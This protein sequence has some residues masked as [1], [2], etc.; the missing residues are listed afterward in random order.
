MFTTLAETYMTATRM[1]AIFSH[2]PPVSERVHLLQLR[3]AE[4]K[5]RHAEIA[6]QA[7]RVRRRTMARATLRGTGRLLERTG[8]VLARAGHALA[9]EPARRQCC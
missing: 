8:A 9:A 5:A 1:D 7:S 3:R 6:R 4:A 2:R